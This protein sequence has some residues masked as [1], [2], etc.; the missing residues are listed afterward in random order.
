M[1]KNLDTLNREE[2]G[3][4]FPIIISEHKDEWKDLF[5][6]EKKLLLRL[7]TKERVIRV[8]H[9][10]ST[11]VPGL[12][13]KPTI[14]ILVEISDYKNRQD[15]IKEIMVSAGYIH[16]KEQVKHMMFVKGYTPDGFKG[17]CYHIHMEPEGEAS[18]RERI[19]F[20]DYLIS[21]PKV[22]EEYAALKKVLAKKYEFDRDAYTDAKTD[23][24]KRVT[25]DA[26]VAFIKQ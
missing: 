18:I 4:L 24:I 9:I 3:R 26:K 20:R 11:S 1:P 15:E 6:Q 5:I 19:Y 23:F 21:N 17:Q 13:A 7:F 8:E 12:S 14:D 22:A 16:M 2:L 10:G 25:S